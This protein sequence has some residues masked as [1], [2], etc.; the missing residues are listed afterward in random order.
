MCVCAWEY[1]FSSFIRC[2]VYLQTAIHS[3]THTHNIALGERRHQTSQTRWQRDDDAAMCTELIAIKFSSEITNIAHVRNFLPFLLLPKQMDGILCRRH[4]FH[5]HSCA[6]T[7]LH[8]TQWVGEWRTRTKK[9][10]N[11]CKEKRNY[12]CEYHT[13]AHQIQCV[14]WELRTNSCRLCSRIGETRI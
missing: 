10:K 11:N 13:T 8:T 1:F 7:Q 9:K 12:V 14:C 2:A 3:F 4:R 5:I 6:I